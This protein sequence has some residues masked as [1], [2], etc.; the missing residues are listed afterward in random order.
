MRESRSLLA[1]IV[2]LCCLGHQALAAD[3]D[4]IRQAL[5]S[6]SEK[7]YAQAEALLRAQA[8]LNPQ[9]PEIA[10]AQATILLWQS[11]FAQSKPIIDALMEAHP[12]NADYRLLRANWH[13]Y[14]G[15]L[16]L[17]EA[18][19][20][21]IVALHP[22][23]AEAQTGLT[24]MRAR[25]ESASSGLWRLDTGYGVGTFQGSEQP[26]WHHAFMQLTRQFDEARTFLHVR[27]ERFNQF[28]TTNMQYEAGVA[29]KFAD[30]LYG[31]LAVAGSPEADYKS[32]FRL[33]VGASGR[34]ANEA[35]TYFP[36]W[37]PVSYQDDWYT[38]VETRSFAAGPLLALA[39]D[40]NI[41][42]K[43]L[44]SYQVGG[45]STK[46]WM[47]QLDGRLTPELGFV[48]GYA[49]APDLDQSSVIPSDTSFGALIFD[50]T[51]KLSIRM[52]YARQ[53]M[54]QSYTRNSFDV[55]LAYRY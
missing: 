34:I 53:S 15:H 17:A 20:A 22:E 51:D 29:H 45:K 28:D 41:T 40:W 43:M 31:D 27:A 52:D 6:A 54:A 46:G 14:Q 23:Y 1:F 18:D 47:T 2:C 8:A 39:E 36:L 33:R 24:A 25:R 21:A 7:D 37:L 26:N 42:A 30:T 12:E 4:P 5:Q 50:V 13:A 32:R 48:V 11:N 10:A 49:Y 35:E 38:T 44:Y 3:G 55:S 19:Y 9:D 16:D